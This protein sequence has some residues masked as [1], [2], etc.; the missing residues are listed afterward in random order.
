MVSAWHY[1]S[2]EIPPYGRTPPR[3]KRISLRDSQP[4][5]TRSWATKYNQD[6]IRGRTSA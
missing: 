6:S 2:Y 3:P 1:I 4:C 5:V